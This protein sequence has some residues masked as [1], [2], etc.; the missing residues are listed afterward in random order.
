MLKARINGTLTHKH[1]PD[2]YLCENLNNKPTMI[3]SIL[4]SIAFVILA[5]PTK[6]NAQTLDGSTL[7]EIS[8]N[9]LTVP[10]YLFGTIHIIDK[11]EFVVNKQTDSVF[12][13]TNNVAF[14]I[15]L[16]DVTMMQVFQE[17]AMLPDSGKLTDFC[18]TEEYE[19]MQRYFK[20]SLQ[21][22]IAAMQNQKP[23]ILYQLFLS[24]LISAD[25]ASYDLHFLTKSIVA[26]KEIMGLE[27]LSDQLNIF[28]S[29]PY[30][31]QIDWIVGGI[32]SFS[33]ADNYYNELIA[34]YL[35]GNL[36]TLYELMT[37]D[38][39]EL[40]KYEDLL[41]TNRNKNW[42]PNIINMINKKPT[43]IA[44]GAGHLPGKNGLLQL[45]IN[46]GY[47]LKAL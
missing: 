32:D 17:W 26:K 4:F 11:N 12:N 5:L 34:A 35:S 15:K 38:S 14:E 23:F 24:N 40:K 45:L 20:D 33:V 25:Q 21:T 47:T 2:N 42:I 8:G 3:K 30:D 9:N 7:W 22:D 6:L 29:I 18:S 19:K 10:S 46:E 36:N 37:E 16:D 31:E 1:T 28:D 39:P 44:V 27:L 13:L 43:F 41:L